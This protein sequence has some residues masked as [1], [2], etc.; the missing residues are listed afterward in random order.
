MYLKSIFINA[1]DENDCKS[2]NPLPSL[3]FLL[4]LH[5]VIMPTW[6]SV[7]DF[8][9]LQ[10]HCKFPPRIDPKSVPN[11]VYK[12]YQKTYQRVTRHGPKINPKSSKGEPDEPKTRP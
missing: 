10:K 6:G 8:K 3:C 11:R 5:F 12:T 1:L 9:S 7:S 2:I 4:I